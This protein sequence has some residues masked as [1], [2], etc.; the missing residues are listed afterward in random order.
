M[1]VSPEPSG[2]KGRQPFPRREGGGEI[3]ALTTDGTGARY[4]CNAAAPA[5]HAPVSCGTSQPCCARS[6]GAREIGDSSYAPNRRQDWV[7]DACLARSADPQPCCKVSLRLRCWGLYGALSVRTWKLF[8]IAGPPMVRFSRCAD[9]RALEIRGRLAALRPKSSRSAGASLL[10]LQES[11]PDA[12]AACSLA[13]PALFLAHRLRRL[14][15][16]LAGPGFTPPGRASVKGATFRCN[17]RTRRTV[18]SQPGCLHKHGGSSEAYVSPAVAEIRVAPTL[19]AV[20]CGCCS[21]RP[22]PILRRS[23]TP[24]PPR[25]AIRHC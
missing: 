17:A 12:V 3:R 13:Q 9:D 6:L 15:R 21:P 8:P 7:A 1:K 18:C 10:L 20:L 4:T 2:A 5:D 24:P 25:R 22:P 19:G 14:G 16:A 23:P 11:A